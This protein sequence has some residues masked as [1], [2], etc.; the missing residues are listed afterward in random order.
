[1]ENPLDIIKQFIP[2]YKQVEIQDRMIDTL[3]KA[4]P[5]ERWR[6][7]IQAYRSDAAFQDS[8]AIAL[9]RAVQKFALAYED[10]EIVEAITHSP[11]F[12]DIP[13]IKSALQEIV[14]RPSSY[15]QPERKALFHSFADVLPTM[16]PERVEQAVY[17]FL[18][19]LTEE[20]MTIP[21]LAPIYQVQLQWASLEQSHQLIGL[22]RDH[23]QLMTMLIETVT[24]NQLRLA[25]PPTLA[26]PKVHDNLPPQRGEFLGREKEKE[27]VLNFLRSRWPLVSIEGLGG[28]GKTTLAIETARSCLG[29][30]Q[31]VLDPP[32]EYV[33]WVS[34]KDKPDQKLWLNEV[35][36]TTARIL[37]YPSIMKLSPEQIEQK[38]G[39]VSQLLHSYRTLL[40]IDNFETIDDRVLESWIHDIPEPS[41]VL[42]TSRTSQL[43]S[44]RSVTLK[45]LEDPAALELIRNYAQSLGLNSLETASEDTL[46]PL[47]RVT[48]G[49]PK[50]I[51]IALGYIKRGRLSLNEVIEHLHVASKTVNNVFDD[52]FSRVWNVMTEGSQHVL[53]VASFFVDYASKEALGSTAVLT[54]YHLDN[55]IEELV[56]LK[57]LDI[58]EE[59]VAL[60]QHY[61]MHPLTRAFASAQLRERPEFE[62]QARIRWSKYYL[63]FT[64]RRIVREKP[65]ERYWNALPSHNFKL[66]D[67]EWPN[68]REVLA[69]T[70]QQ[71]RDHILVEL[72]LLLGHYIT[73]HMLFPTSLYYAQKAAEAANRLGRKEDA[74]LFYID[75]RGWLLIEEGHLTDAIQE[76]NMGL[77]IAE[78]LDV[79][80]TNAT[81]LIALA[82]TSLARA[83]LERGDLAAASALMEKVTS[84]EYKPVIQ[85]RVNMLA[86]DIASKKNNYAEAL[87]LYERAY[88]ISMQYGGEENNARLGNVYLA[89]GDLIQAENC[90]N[91]ALDKTKHFNTEEAPHAKYGLAR[92]AL[93]KGE[94]DKAHQI[95]QELLNDL[96]RTVTSHKLLNE[97]QIFL[98]NLVE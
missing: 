80:S 10:K 23:N 83:F 53:L 57:L 37:G 64:T 71:G 33:V 19:C 61:S 67:S 86:C 13:S 16:E 15:L 38:K 49:N 85:W 14:T 40:I 96:L 72:M 88:Q 17:F 51:G 25:A 26:L 87:K 22:Q 42:I 81:D 63:D 98:K 74:A 93:A 90:F 32:F 24:Q 59:S 18:R 2:Q 94:R 77:S 75:A 44:T 69:W 34:A 89:M 4:F 27:H 7:L 8:L 45:G 11:H 20:V 31:A 43:R 5:D 70:D 97:I 36:D 91:K 78:T 28:M 50:A 73:G 68:L 95:A 56:E 66:I 48:G 21:Q 1:M 60:G 55:A 79:S 41:K 65:K 9:K 46:L 84:L 3:V 35:L 30:P 52:L 92:V 82:K 58:Q 6:K 76:I 47:V 29:G 39:E 12:W 62:E 54:E